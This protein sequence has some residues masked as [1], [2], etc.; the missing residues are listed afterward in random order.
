MTSR[1]ESEKQTGSRGA[2]RSGQ[3]G[4][5]D[6]KV[7]TFISFCEARQM[8]EKWVHLALPTSASTKLA[9]KGEFDPHDQS[10]IAQLNWAIL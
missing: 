2:E 1:K 7:A 10:D 6:A 9:N 8:G 4:S 3:S 5:S